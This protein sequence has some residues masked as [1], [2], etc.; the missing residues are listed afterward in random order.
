MLPGALVV[1]NPPVPAR[2]P[3]DS[4]SRAASIAHAVRTCLAA[5]PFLVE[6]EELYADVDAE[7]SRWGARCLGGGSC[8]KFDLTGRWVYLSAGELAVLCRHRPPQPAQSFR[9]RCAYQLGPRCSARRCRPLGCRVFFCDAQAAEFCADL[10][11]KAHG[12]IR[13]LHE[14]H[15]LP[16]VYGALTAG[17]A[18]LFPEV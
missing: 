13:R 6:L 11:E 17:L 3:R 7:V 1:P 18:E 2:G 10:Y 4:N 12:R 15:S 8:C 5:P 9:S 16:Y 14:E